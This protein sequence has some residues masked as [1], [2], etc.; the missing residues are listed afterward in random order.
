MS[1]Q[2]NLFFDKRDYERYIVDFIFSDIKF[3]SGTRVFRDLH[4]QW[5]KGTSK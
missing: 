2:D 3:A 4:A 1:R 5:P